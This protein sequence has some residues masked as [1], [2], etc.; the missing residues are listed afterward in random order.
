VFVVIDYTCECILDNCKLAAFA[1]VSPVC[2]QCSQ[3]IET[4]V[5]SLIDCQSV[6]PFWVNVLGFISGQVDPIPDVDTILQLRLPTD[7]HTHRSTKPVLLALACG[8]WVVHHAR[9]CRIYTDASPSVHSLTVEWRSMVKEI[10][11]A[12]RRT[13]IIHGNLARFLS[14]WRMLATL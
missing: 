2:P 5:Y 1:F 10:V 12:K 9:I 8:L 11:N 7:M 13:A 6:R 3:H 4:I 14:I